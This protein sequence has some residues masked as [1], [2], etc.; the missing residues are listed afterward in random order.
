[1]LEI[2]IITVGALGKD[3]LKQAIQEYSKRLQA[4]CKLNIIE[5]SDARPSSSN[6]NSSEIEKLLIDEGERIVKHTKGYL[7]VLDI[8]GRPLTSP[9]LSEVLESVPL[10]GNS[11]ISFVIGGSWGIVEGIKKSADLLLS[12]SR[13]TFPHQLFRVMLLEQ[14]YRAFTILNNMPYHK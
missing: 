2:R 7:I 4:F 1:M 5:L 9:G 8:Q 3:Y 11:C 13:M 12:F 14:L 10:A 6:P